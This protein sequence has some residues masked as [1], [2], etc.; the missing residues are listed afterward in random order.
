MRTLTKQDLEDYVI[1]AVIL[2]CGGG[3]S[4]DVDRDAAGHEPRERGKLL[5]ALY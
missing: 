2:G 1:G 3:G 5:S 4:G